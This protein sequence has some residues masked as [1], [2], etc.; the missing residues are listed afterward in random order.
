MTEMRLMIFDDKKVVGTAKIEV[1]L[2]ESDID[3][4]ISNALEGGIGY[5]ARLNNIGEKWDRKPKDR[6]TSEWVT[7]L[8]LDGETVEFED[9]EEEFEEGEE[10][11]RWFLSLDKL[12]KGFELN[13]K[14]RPHDNNLEQ[15][16]ATTSDCIIQYALFGEL[17]YG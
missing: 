14:L 1:Q 5:W 17:V 15:G 2:T 9:A 6:Y 16:D 7:K 13:Y 12:I 11:E 8:L 3:T 4:I 10:V